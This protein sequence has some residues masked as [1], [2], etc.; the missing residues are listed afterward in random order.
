MWP[1][2]PAMMFRIAT[3]LMVLLG[4]VA[5]GFSQEP[6]TAVFR[7][8]VSNIRVSVQVTENNNPVTNLA[9][10]DFIVKDE[11]QIQTGVYFAKEKEPLTLLLLLDISGSMREHV[12]QMAETARDALR[13]LQPG[14]RV[15]IMTFGTRAYMHFNFFDNHAEVTQQLKTAVNTQDQTG[16]G[17]AINAAI[18]E[19]ANALA[20]DG[21]SGRRSILIVTDNLGLNYQA[22]D[23]WTIGHLLKSDAT[24]N[25]IVVGR[26][27]R[28]GAPKEGENPDFTPADVFKLAEKTGG[29]A[30]KAERAAASFPEMI[31]RIRERYTLTYPLP[32]GSKPGS[33]RGISVALTPAA[34]KAHPNAVVRHR[35]GYYV[36]E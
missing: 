19:G 12:E 20:E 9:E 36:K 25:A 5:T 26:G 28:P 2:V 35:S 11:G 24:L 27:I 32:A 18:I 22:N 6:E 16:F 33:F 14:D 4:L 7:T 8:G 3:P 31:A 30:V 23:Q 13:Y 15:G 29:E 17:T 21:S 1:A 34:L 10:S